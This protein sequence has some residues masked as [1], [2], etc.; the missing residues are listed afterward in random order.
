VPGPASSVPHGSAALRAIAMLGVLAALAACDGEPAG[1]GGYGV[2]GKG[3]GMPS[4]VTVTTAETEL[5]TI[6]VD[7]RGRTLYLSTEDPP[8]RS[9]CEGAC[10]TIWPPVTGRARAGADLDPDLLGTVER[11]DGT[12]QVSY[13]D[14]PLYR[15]RGDAVGGLGGQGV[16]GS[17]WVVGADGE[18]VM[19]SR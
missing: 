14:H 13:A 15:H 19:N 11:P 8:G 12:V 7:G 3:G 1:P 9:A 4:T 5:G 17:W 2:G 16:A 10:V 6:L 18:A